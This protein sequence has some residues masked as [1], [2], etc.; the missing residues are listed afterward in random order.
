MVPRAGFE[1]ALPVTGTGSSSQ[2]VYQ[3]H[4][5]GKKNEIAKF[6]ILGSQLGCQ[7]NERI[8]QMPGPEFFQTGMGHKFYE[9]TLP[10]IA[11]SLARIATAMEK[12]LAAAEAGKPESTEMVAFVDYCCHLPS[13]HVP[14]YFLFKAPANASLS[15]LERFARAEALQVMAPLSQDCPLKFSK[16]V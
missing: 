3:F 16:E 10:R 12:T 15:T 11:D 13:D 9:G 7:T 14:D 8:I 6:A 4:H 5:L 2:R 1:P